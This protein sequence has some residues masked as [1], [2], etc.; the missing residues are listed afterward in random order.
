M[1]SFRAQH[2]VIGAMLA[3]L[4]NSRADAQ[5]SAAPAAADTEEQAIARNVA[6][7]AIEVSV[8]GGPSMS[9]GEPA[10]PELTP[11]ANRWGALLSALVAYRSGYFIT[12]S[13]EL[14]HAWLARGEAELPPGPWGEGGR[15]EQRLRAW[16]ISPG[17]SVQIWRFRPRLGLGL[18]IVTQAFS[19]SGEDSSSSQYPLSSQLVVDFEGADLNGIRLDFQ[20]GIT[21]AS[22]AGLTFARLG[23][24][25]HFDIVTFDE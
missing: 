24:A 10:N 14:G 19:F 16:L 7:P 15:L 23:V 4:V 5:P 8:G 18:A 11:S 20:A 6:H 25:A 12:P 22:G 21:Q 3:L 17:I 9:F 2:R 1:S 13:L